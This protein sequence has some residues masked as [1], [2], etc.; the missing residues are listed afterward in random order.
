MAIN[1]SVP[2]RF[3]PFLATLFFFPQLP[4]RIPPLT[5]DVNQYSTSVRVF[6]GFPRVFTSVPLVIKHLLL[7]LPF[8]PLS[9]SNTESFDLFVF[10]RNFL[11][12]ICFPIGGLIFPRLYPTTPF[13]SHLTVS[14]RR[15]S[16]AFAYP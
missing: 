5:T 6:E 3:T 4:H 8:A 11:L 7:C 1:L 2:T 9:P 14:M 16:F 15:Y 13:P 10:L 12:P